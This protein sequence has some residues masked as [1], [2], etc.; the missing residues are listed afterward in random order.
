[1]RFPLTMALAGAMVTQAVLAQLPDYQ[2]QGVKA[3]DANNYPAALELFTR[4]VDADPKDYAAHF[5][6]ALTYSLLDKFAEAVPQ[7]RITLDLKPRLYDAELNLAMCLLHLKDAAA[8]EPLLKDAVVQK[9]KEFKPALYLGDALLAEKRFAE[10]ESAFSSAIAINPA[11]APA[12][13][14]LAQA[15]AQGAG[16]DPAKLLG[17]EGHFRKAAAID[18][19]YKP[20]L[21]QLGE[22]YE[23]AKQVPQAIAIYREF[24]GNPGAQERMGALLSESGDAAAAI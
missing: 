18:P 7:Y 23:N 13:L 20:A 4:G 15:L 17:A 12:E 1:M 10:A 16:A 24:P 14:G 11:S 6:L 8:A 21:L 9:P 3:L 22:L 5:Y 19:G 2:T